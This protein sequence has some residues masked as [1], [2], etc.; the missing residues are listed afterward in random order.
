MASIRLRSMRASTGAVPEE[1]TATVTGSRSITEGAMKLQ[2]SVRSTMLTDEGR[3]FR[4]VPFDSKRATSCIGVVEVLHVIDAVA[5]DHALGQSLVVAA[6]GMA[7][8]AKTKKV[9]VIS[10]PK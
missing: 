7:L 10:P 3:I 6:E 9:R 1:D 8:A 4:L 5:Y 2:S